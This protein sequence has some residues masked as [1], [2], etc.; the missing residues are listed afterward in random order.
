MLKNLLFVAC[1]LTPLISLSAT[2][3]AAQAPAIV[4]H[5]P[6]GNG[7][8]RTP[9]NAIAAIINNE[10]ITEVELN[11]QVSFVAANLTASHTAL[12]PQDMFREQVLN[13]MI[14]QRLELQIAKQNGIQVDDTEI[15]SSIKSIATKNGKTIAEMLASVKAMGL[16]TADFREEVRKELIINKLQGQQVA[17]K[18]TITPEEVNDYLNSSAGQSLDTMEYHLADILVTFPSDAPTAAQI[19]DA[20]QKAQSIMNDIKK[21]STFQTLAVAHSKGD[22]AL[23]GGDLGWR[24]LLQMP[25]VFASQAIHMQSGE[26]AGPVYTENGFYILK[27]LGTRSQNKAKNLTPQELKETVENLIFQRKLQERLQ[28]WVIQLRSS[29]YIKILN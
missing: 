28:N 7:G 22:N 11:K 3:T 16:S 24:Q 17:S 6:N 19:N 5:S 14:N 13:Q 2:T 12:P 26:I 21:G 8:I 1:M 20:K 29:A 15:N 27:L 25:S 18:I 4:N 9:I 23:Q 10:V